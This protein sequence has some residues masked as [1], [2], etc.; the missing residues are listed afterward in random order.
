ME[1]EEKIYSQI[2]ISDHNYYDKEECPA[3]PNKI[4]YIEV[5]NKG[6][7]IKSLPYTRPVRT[8]PDGTTLGAV[9]KKKVY[10]IIRQYRENSNGEREEI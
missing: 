10:P 1:K 7:L 8:M 5:L 2:E 6:N 9:Y 3:I 4:T